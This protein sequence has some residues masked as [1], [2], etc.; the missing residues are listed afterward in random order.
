MRI[1]RYFFVGGAAAAVDLSLFVLFAKQLGFNYL[2]VGAFSF[3]VATF[4]NYVLSIRHVFDSG[5]R[6]S[7]HQEVGLVFVVSAMGLIANL[8]VLYANVE[9][10]GLDLLVSKIVATGTVFLWNYAARAHFVFKEVR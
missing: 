4:A 1:V 10:L 7:K 2:A 9:K 8:M 6:F 5:V 3:V